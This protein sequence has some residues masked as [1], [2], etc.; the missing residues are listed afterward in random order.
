MQQ[1]QLQNQQQPSL[2]QQ[3]YQQHH[4][5]QNNAPGGNELQGIVLQETD[6][7]AGL[8]GF[9]SIQHSAAAP[10]LSSVA[11]HGQLTQPATGL[12]GN[13]FDANFNTINTNN[14]STNHSGTY[15]HNLLTLLQL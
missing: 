4:Q 13:D 3:Q 11:P 8:S 14:F 10:S 7:Y 9:D 6:R 15:L 12:L 5:I 2:Q 1:Q